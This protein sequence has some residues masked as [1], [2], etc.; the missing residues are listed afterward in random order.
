MIDILS[1]S[2]E[3]DFRRIPQDR[4]D[5]VLLIHV[6]ASDSLCMFYMVISSW[7]NP[8]YDMRK[9]LIIKQYSNINHAHNT[10]L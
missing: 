5:D 8:L 6:V 10:T 3:I 1:S 9:R 7:K 4:T 2:S